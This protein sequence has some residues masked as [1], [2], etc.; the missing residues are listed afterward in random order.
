ML[1]NM[2]SPI[3]GVAHESPKSYSNKW[4]EGH[5]PCNN[6]ITFFINII[7]FKEFNCI[8]TYL[9]KLHHLLATFFA[10]KY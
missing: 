10:K 5:V 6:L 8:S 1:D 7:P 2:D 4:L 9:L 3:D